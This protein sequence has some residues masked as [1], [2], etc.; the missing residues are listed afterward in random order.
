MECAETLYSQLPPVQLASLVARSAAIMLHHGGAD[1]RRRAARFLAALAVLLPA[2][3]ATA[4]ERAASSLLA[5]GAAQEGR[6][7][8]GDEV[9]LGFRGRLE[10]AA[11]LRRL[12]EGIDECTANTSV[13]DAEVGIAIY[14]D[15][16]A[17]DREGPLVGCNGESLL[18]LRCVIVA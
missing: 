2:S 11:A 18:G 4:D 10:G 8:V 15:E 3:A 16:E 12:Q 17:C 7:L 13:G 9:A 1:P 6:P 14:E 5:A